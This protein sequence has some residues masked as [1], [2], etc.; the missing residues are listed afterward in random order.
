MSPENAPFGPNLR[1]LVVTPFLP[2]VQAAHGGGMYVGALCRALA[3]HAELGL[4]ALLHKDEDSHLQRERLPFQWLTTTRLP[5]RPRGLAKRRH[6]IGMLWRWGVCGMPLVA[7]KHLTTEFHGVLDR[8]VAEFQPDAVL[9]ELAQMAQYLPHFSTLP[10]VLTDH[11]AGMP[12]NAR[13][14]LGAI[15]D[16]RDARLWRRYVHRFYPQASLL[17]AVTTEDAQ[18]LSTQ[19]GLPVATRHAVID[20]P[21]RPVAPHTA[22]QRALFLGDYSHFPNREAAAILTREVLPLLRA[23]VPTVELWF[24]GPNADRLQGIGNVKGVHVVGYVASLTALFGQVRVMLAPTFSGSGFRVK[25]LTAL[26]HGL[27]VITNTLGARG[28]SAPSPACT[29]EDDMKSLAGATLR[30]LQDPQSASQAGSLGY[31]WA[32]QNLVAETVA[33]EQIERIRT[34]IA[35]GPRAKS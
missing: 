1:L 19:L 9:I 29:I 30:L 5:Q 22:P 31:A 21:R 24:A 11:E 20:I 3:T 12:A 28:C 10:T 34:L 33:A 6:Q 32:Q 7:A 14:Q 18:L 26:A 23:Q 16:R 27:P 8:A 35:R 4:A 15:A 17:Q 13:T 25:C 2:D